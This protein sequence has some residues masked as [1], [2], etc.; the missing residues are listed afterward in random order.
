[1]EKYKEKAKNAPPDA[2]GA[3]HDRQVRLVQNNP[4]YAAMLEQLDTGIG[5]VLAAL[6]KNGLTE[7]TVVIFMSDNGGISTSEGSPTSNVPLRGGKG[8]P[9]E[10]EH[11]GRTQRDAL[12]VEEHKGTH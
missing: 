11:K 9:Y 1:M 6:E 12:I 3:E 10:G 2:F 8:W 4:V 7:K 5:R